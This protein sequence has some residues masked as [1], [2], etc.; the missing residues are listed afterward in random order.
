M[1][2]LGLFLWW[3]RYYMNEAYISLFRNSV[4]RNSDKKK[5]AKNV[6][7]KHHLIWSQKH[8]LFSVVRPYDRKTDFVTPVNNL[9]FL[10]YNSLEPTYQHN[11]STTFFWPSFS[12][13]KPD[14]NTKLCPLCYKPIGILKAL[15][16]A[17]VIATKKE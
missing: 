4:L 17:W 5:L 16:F 9:T 6:K 7:S 14:L 15:I 3:L 12:R 10:K 13:L 1:E 8:L 2:C 11:L